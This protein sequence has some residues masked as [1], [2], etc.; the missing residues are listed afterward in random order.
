MASSFNDLPDPFSSPGE[1]AGDPARQAVA[2]IRGIVYQIWWSIDAWLRQSGLLANKIDPVAFTAGTVLVNPLAASTTPN[3]RPVAGSPALSGANFL[4]NPVLA[5][6]FILNAEK[7][8]K[9]AQLPIYPNPISNGNVYF[10]K[11]VVS[12]GIFDMSGRLV[13]HGFDTDHATVTG[14]AKGFYL[15]K[16]DG[17]VQKLIVQ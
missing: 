3:F 13:A 11:E 7:D 2:S 17:Q 8:I 10:G 4:D 12:Y 16:L 9:E 15:I 5:N 1:L 6:L 14:L